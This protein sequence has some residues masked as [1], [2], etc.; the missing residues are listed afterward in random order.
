ME[1]VTELLTHRRT[2]DTR[3]S[4]LILWA[5]GTRLTLSLHMHLQYHGQAILPHYI[6]FISL[7]QR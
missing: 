7:S 3:C 2:M 6:T 5:P 4:S 1:N